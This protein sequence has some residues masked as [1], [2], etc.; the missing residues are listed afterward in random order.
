MHWTAIRTASAP[1]VAELP[2]PVRD[3]LPISES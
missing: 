1:A 2:V 3:A